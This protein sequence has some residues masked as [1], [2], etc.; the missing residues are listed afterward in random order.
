MSE[1]VRENTIALIIN[2]FM[3]ALMTCLN[4]NISVPLVIDLFQAFNC[5]IIDLLQIVMYIAIL[6]CLCII[7]NGIQEFCLQQNSSLNLKLS[8]IN[9]CSHNPPQSYHHLELLFWFILKL[10]CNP[11]RR[12][13]KP[14]MAQQ[15]KLFSISRDFHITIVSVCVCVSVVINGKEQFSHL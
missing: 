11:L 7:P 15:R 1:R 9:C 5:R 10:H 2:H 13:L 12:L 8:E 14:K 6:Q 4:T 3:K